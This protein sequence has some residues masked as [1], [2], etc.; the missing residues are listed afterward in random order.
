MEND[1]ECATRNA[2]LCHVC[3][4]IT[5][6]W[7]EEVERTSEVDAYITGELIF[8]AYIL[9]LGLANDIYIYRE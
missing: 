8:L 1:P 5:G 2:P 6:E 4:V 9:D 3:P 7:N